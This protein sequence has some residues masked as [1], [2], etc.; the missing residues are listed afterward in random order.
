M[1][2]K[3]SSLAGRMSAR[4]AENSPASAW[5]EI[6]HRPTA[7]AS[8]SPIGKS[9]SSRAAPGRRPSAPPS[10]SRCCGSRRWP[11]RNPCATIAAGGTS[12]GVC[13]R[14]R[15]SARPEGPKPREGNLQNLSHR[16]GGSGGTR[17]R[18]RPVRL[19]PILLI[20]CAIGAGSPSGSLGGLGGAVPTQPRGGLS[21]SYRTELERAVSRHTWSRIFAMVI[22]AV[23]SL[24]AFAILQTPARAAP[25]AVIG[26]PPVAM[27]DYMK[28]IN[29]NNF[30]FDP[31]AAMPMIPATLQYS[32]VARNT[33]SY[34]LV[35][36]NGPV[37]PDMKVALAATD[38]TILYYVA[39]NT[40]IVRADGP[41]IDRAAALPSVRW[42]GVFEPAYKLSPRLSDEFG[43]LAQRAMDRARY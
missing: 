43:A 32:S 39:Y 10:R 2:A 28:Y 8:S 33:P 34:Y 4:Y 16:A 17:G 36:F 42:T 13:I 35:Q 18:S 27:P 1:S 26:L 14:C 6:S 30:K 23:M 38:V 40:F 12:A 15:S 24:S 11:R 19:S 5:T 41:A 20:S 7:T 21:M 37:T 22:V 25:Q 29:V 9:A 31:L 3:K